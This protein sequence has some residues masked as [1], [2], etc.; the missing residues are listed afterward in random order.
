MYF[1]NQEGKIKVGKVIVH[2]VLSVVLFFT[3][4]GSFE[5]IGPGERGVILTLGKVEDR[6]MLEGFNFKFPF[7]QS[8]K[9]L[10][11]KIQKEEVNVSAAS[12]DLQTVTTIIALN[13]H[14]EAN[15]VN[16]LWQGVGRDYKVRIIDPA[17]QEAIKAITAKY[18][19]EELITKR[20][21]VRDDAKTILSERL[22]R[23]FILVDELSIVNFDFSPSFNA[24]IEAKVTAEQNALAAKNKLEQVK[25]EKEQRITQAQGEAEAI[26][27]QVQAITQQ[28]GQSYVQ[29]KAIEKWNGTVP[30]TM[31]PGASVPFINLK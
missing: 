31:I 1:V 26:R 27:I 9:V 12:K 14:L 18:T 28:G 11:I 7:I 15:N 10:D 3:F 29:L 2:G 5:L 8:V 20:P 23:E 13:Y 21:L 6:I 25:Y 30:V 16:K 22:N 19:A 24:A 4:I 17:I